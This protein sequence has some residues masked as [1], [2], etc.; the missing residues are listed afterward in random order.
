MEM[1]SM[2]GFAG[3]GRSGEFGQSRETHEPMH[4]RVPKPHLH[5]Q[6][7]RQGFGRKPTRGAGGPALAATSQDVK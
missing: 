3:T 1:R 7:V 4:G 2:R 5:F 6:K